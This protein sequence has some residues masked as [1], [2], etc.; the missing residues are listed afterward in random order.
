[1]RSSVD[2]RQ[3]LQNSIQMLVISSLVALESILAL[4]YQA[5]LMPT[6]DISGLKFGG[7]ASK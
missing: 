5:L 4:T 2:S 7:L 6:R 3:E 1:M